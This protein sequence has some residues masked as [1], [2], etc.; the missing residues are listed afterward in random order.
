MKILYVFIGLFLR[1]FPRLFSVGHWWRIV[2]YRTLTHSCLTIRLDMLIRLLSYGVQSLLS[3]IERTCFTIVL[4]LQI[5]TKL[6]RQEREPW[7]VERAGNAACCLGFGSQHPHLLVTG[8][9]GN[10]D[11]TL[12]D[13]WLFDVTNRSWKEVSLM[14]TKLSNLQVTSECHLKAKYP[15]T[16]YL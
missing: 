15:A 2:Y 12:R 13:A 14:H 4:L 1:P 11:K 5:I 6:E 10:D 7:P 9:L 16:N 8:G 3:L